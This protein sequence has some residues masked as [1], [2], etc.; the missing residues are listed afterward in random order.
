VDPDY[1]V[2]NWDY[3]AWIVYAEAVKGDA[4]RSLARF[5]PYEIYERVR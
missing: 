1:L 2:V 5:G 3:A 4:F